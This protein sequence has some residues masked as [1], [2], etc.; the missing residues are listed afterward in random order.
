MRAKKIGMRAFLVSQS[1]C[2]TEYI[3]ILCS[4]MPLLPTRREINV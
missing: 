4:M 2:S 1:D 3:T